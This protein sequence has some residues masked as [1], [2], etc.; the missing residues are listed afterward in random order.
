MP[1]EDYIK[2][3]EVQ[4]DDLTKTQNELQKQLL[5][6]YSMSTLS[7][8]KLGLDLVVPLHESSFGASGPAPP[9]LPA[10]SQLASIQ[11]SDIYS[12]PSAQ[13]MRELQEIQQKLTIAGRAYARE[14]ARME[15]AKKGDMETIKLQLQKQVAELY[16]DIG[17]TEARMMA[18]QMA[19]TRQEQVAT[20]LIS[21][22]HLPPTDD[23]RWITINLST[24]VL[25]ETWKQISAT[26][27]DI[28]LWLGSGDIGSTLSGG[29]D[30]CSQAKEGVQIELALR[31]S[32]VNVDRSSWFQPQ[33]MEK[34][35]E[36][37]RKLEHAPWSQWP[38]GINTIQE[39]ITSIKEG[40]FETGES[41]LPAYVDS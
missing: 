21:E 15:M 28:A 29:T 5:S 4:I 7:S 39:A 32:R 11:A 36:L 26:S 38:V 31:V 35:S 12:N 8:A 41:L 9:L 16:L 22:I 27:T 18:A 33:F 1:N 37:V 23:P 6:G 10:N 3:L 14:T 40:R 34:S 2:S 30:S 17:R 25:K 20:R 19:K 24:S 13:E